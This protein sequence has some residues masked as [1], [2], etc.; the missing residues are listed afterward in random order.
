M[1]GY[2]N[3]NSGALFK[4]EN[5][6]DETDRDHSGRFNFAGRD[7]WASGWVNEDESG[8]WL[9]VSLAE[10]NGSDRAAGKLRPVG[11]KASDRHP[12]Y[13]GSIVLADQ[14]Y[15]MAGWKRNAKTSGKSFISVK[16][17]A[18]KQTEQPVAASSS[19][20]EEDIP[21]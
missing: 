9:R 2:D 14:E 15:P 18:P 8:K 1:S 20:D 7:W 13:K 17:D 16:I 12:D 4:E 10:Q 19:S 5:K 6:R 3:T 21:F 11:E